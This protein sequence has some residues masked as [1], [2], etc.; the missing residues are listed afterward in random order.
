MQDRH[1][2]D[3]SLRV[4][5]EHLTER[6]IALLLELGSGRAISLTEFHPTAQR[7]AARKLANINGAK[8]TITKQGLAKVKE[9]QPCQP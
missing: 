3:L 9:L 5:D 7:L 8:A 2:T 4:L 1:L 6:E